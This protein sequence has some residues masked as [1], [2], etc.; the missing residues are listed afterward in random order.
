[1]NKNSAPLIVWLL[2]LL[3]TAPTAVSAQ[4]GAPNQA[5]PAEV[6][7][8]YRG[9]F[10]GAPDPN[11]SQSLVLSASAF[12]AYDDNVTAG[13]SG[14]E[15]FDPRLQQSGK[16]WG[17]NAG[18]SYTLMKSS[19]R[20]DY[21]LSSGATVNSYRLEDDRDLVPHGFVSGDL[22]LGLG[23]K[24]SLRFSQQVIY[25]E[26]YRFQ[27][28]PTLVGP[29]DDGALVGDPDL[30]LFARTSLRYGSGVGFDYELDRR[31]S[32]SASYSFGMVDYRDDIN[33]DWKNH[34]GVVGYQRRISTNANLHLGYG[35]RTADTRTGATP[36]K[37]HDINVGV[38][39]S[40]ALSFSRRTSLSF[41]T[42]SAVVVTDDVNVPESDPRAKFHLL[43]NAILTHELGRTWTAYAAY[44]RGLIFREGFDDPFLTDAL[45]TGLS[46]LVTRRLDVSIV[47]RIAF[48]SQDV[49]DKNR[50]DSVVASAQARYAFS[51]FL[52][53]YA[54][55]VYYTYEFEEGIPLEPG[56]P[57]SLDRRGVRVGLTA[58][59]PLIR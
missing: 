39:Y 17:A 49:G 51:Q 8:P 55:F 12:G 40:R 28:Y 13:L 36:R 14:Q 43:G 27:M 52:A 54:R 42:G 24:S 29:D 53:G 58:T 30:E 4:Q 59:V 19:E 18:I 15:N 45:S 38:D 25:S 21:G 47:G 56:L 37:L 57:S 16:Y 26:Y 11:N 31:S 41:G 23:Q 20:L 34:R 1:M 48:A 6:R 7:R 32:F 5:D 9:L 33:P 3:A 10:G 46:G 2:A 35:Y 44:N 22:R 50:Y